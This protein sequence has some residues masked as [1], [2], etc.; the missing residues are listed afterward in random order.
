MD[1]LNET[2]SWWR[3]DTRE[4]SDHS[5]LLWCH[6]NLVEPLK[7]RMERFVRDAAEGLGYLVYESSFL[8]KGENTKIY[9]KIDSVEG[10]THLDCEKYSRALSEMLNAEGDL[11]NYSL[12]V[13]SPGLN[14]SLRSAEEFRRFP[15]APVKIVYTAGDERKVLQGVLAAVDETCVTVTGEKGETTI[16]YAAIASAKLDY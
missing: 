4:W 9:V 2:L 15:G 13:S 7:D 6:G 11:P 1:I 12:E 10:V 8:L 14:R 5:F 3:A 16:A